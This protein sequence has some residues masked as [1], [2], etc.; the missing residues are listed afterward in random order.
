MV[1]VRARIDAE[2][3]ARMQR[4]L[5]EDRYA[6]AALVV[7]RALDKFLPPLTDEERAALYDKLATDLDSVLP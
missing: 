2:L 3:N 6:T 4:A 5:A 1:E 7:R